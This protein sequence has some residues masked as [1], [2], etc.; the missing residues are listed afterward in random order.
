MATVVLVRSSIQSSARRS[1][2]AFVAALL[3]LVLLWTG[4]RGVEP[5]RGSIE[6]H[7]HG[8]TAERATFGSV[9][10]GKPVGVDSSSEAKEK[11]LEESDP[12]VALLTDSDSDRI[13]FGARALGDTAG[14]SRIH[15]QRLIACIGAR[16][17]PIG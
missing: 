6:A 17:P 10:D 8:D 1:G 15:D 4:T 2:V 13:T 16:G 7:A 11:E 9:P 14:T 3:M 12:T 5:V